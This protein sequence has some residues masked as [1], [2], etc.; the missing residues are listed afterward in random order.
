MDDVGV[1]RADLVRRQLG[2]TVA[3]DGVSLAVEP[4]QVH[5]LVG[6][7]GA[8][9]TTLLRVL[10]G[11]LRPDAGFVTLGGVALSSLE[12]EAWSGVGHT[13]ETPFAYP[14]LDVRRNLEIAARLRLVEPGRIR[15][16]VEW[17]LSAL[18]LGAY[19]GVVAR[20]LSQGNRQRVGLA[21]ALQHA[22]DTVVLDEPSNALDPAG[23][24]L[25]REILLRLRDAGAAILVSSHHLDEVARIA[26]RITLMNRGRVI[27]G[28]DPDTLDLERSFFAAVH[29]DD[30]ARE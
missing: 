3:L 21:A 6:L 29:A 16:M 26:D 18:D 5:A 11:M 8:G 10:L 19:A 22:P 30:E 7:N 28:L 20:R 17:S 23:V 15:E 12:P 25:L 27:G 4:G 14:E 13:L 9:K 24:L 2:D 1:L